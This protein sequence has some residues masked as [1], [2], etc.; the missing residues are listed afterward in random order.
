MP[1]NIPLQFSTW[2]VLVINYEVVIRVTDKPYGL[3]LL[4][5]LNFAK[6]FL[7]PLCNKIMCHTW[8]YKKAM[9]EILEQTHV[10]LEHLIN[11]IRNHVWQQPFHGWFSLTGVSRLMFHEWC[12]FAANIS[13]E[14]MFQEGAFK[15]QNWK[16]E[17]RKIFHGILPRCLQS[18]CEILLWF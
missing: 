11:I 18:F 2:K 5:P 12:R 7:F 10:T 17:V 16:K 15:L 9:D 1:S 3:D 6:S 14:L 13:S 8:Y 4:Y